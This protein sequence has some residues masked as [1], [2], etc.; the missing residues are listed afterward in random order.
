MEGT[1]SP[2]MELRAFCLLTVKILSS[3]NTLA[4][5]C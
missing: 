1:I 2:L 3:I 4:V 5:R